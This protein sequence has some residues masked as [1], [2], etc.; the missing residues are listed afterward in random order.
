M[1]GN[2]FPVKVPF[3]PFVLHMN[4]LFLRHVPLIQAGFEMRGH[5]IQ[6]QLPARAC[7][8]FIGQV[9]ETNSNLT[10]RRTRK[11]IPSTVVQGGGEGVLM[12]PHPLG[13]RYVT[14]FRKVFTFSRK[15]MMCS[16]IM[17]GHHR[18]NV[19]FILRWC[20]CSL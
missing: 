4:C 8:L 11:L 12:E 16:T 17:R 14:I 9:P 20:S 1:R 3:V 6:I 5:F 10:L 13:F 19:F 2:L 15:P 18:H 7:A